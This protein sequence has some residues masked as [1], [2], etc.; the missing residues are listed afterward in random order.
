[1]Y[2]WRKEADKERERERITNAQHKEK[3]KKKNPIVLK[4][5]NGLE[6]K[7]HYV[8]FNGPHITEVITFVKLF[9]G[10]HTKGLN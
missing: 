8:A 4:M 2:S 1:M 7:L 6:K 3:Q 10:N 5:W 9:N